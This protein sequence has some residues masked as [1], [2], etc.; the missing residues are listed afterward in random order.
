MCLDPYLI[1][2]PGL[3]MVGGKPVLERTINARQTKWKPQ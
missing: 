2:V 1:F 3:S